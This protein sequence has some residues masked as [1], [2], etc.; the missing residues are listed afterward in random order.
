MSDTPAPRRPRVMVLFGGRSGE[1]PISCV[2]AGG[3]LR[4]IDRDRYDV[5]AVGITRD[6]RWVLV[7]DDP[8]RWAITGGR[9]PEVTDAPARVL[10]PQA[11]DDRELQ[12]LRGG[13]AEALGTVDVVFPLLHGPFGEDGTLQG[14]L[15]LADVRY[16]GAGVLASAVG[17]DKQMMKL[18]F[19]GQGLAVGP[20]RV[21]RPGELDRD[22]AGVVARVQEL[23]LPVFVK[24]ARA[25]SSLGISRVDDWADLE[26]A[27]RA[28]AEHDPKV[29][30][31]A[32]IVGREIE[33]GVLGGVDGRPARASLPGE[34]V[35][36]DHRHAFYDFEAKY[37]D[38]ASVRLECPADL[39]AD[40]IERV[41]AIAVQAFDAVGCEGL[42]RV[43][44]FVTPDGD[45]VVNEI[46]TMPGFTPFSM[47]PR[48]WAATGTD[49]PTLVDELLRLALERPTGL[50]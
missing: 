14:M 41:R 50:R 36:T 24:P 2:T 6:G 38:E 18:V 4:A 16:V 3:V 27:I 48:M 9:L 13:V 20:Y 15:E 37:L 5:L 11:V 34:I 7:D 39:P 33:C 12:V 21:V 1:H 35:V 45:V 42:A 22:P 23:G 49:Y 47:Y 28:A 46:N 32:A 43:D 40:V 30:V 8:D 19:A 10:L 29:V 44:V 17:M 26:T 25:G 31:E